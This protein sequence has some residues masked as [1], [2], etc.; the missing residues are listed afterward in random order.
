MDLEQAVESKHIYDAF[1]E[2]DKKNYAR[3]E[4]I[5]TEGLGLAE[6]EENYPL[7]AIFYS[8]LG[9]LAKLKHDFRQAWRYY[10][11]AEKLLPHNPVL[12]LISA[13]LLID[14]FSQYDVA[15]RKM[16]KIEDMRLNDPLVEH[17][18]DAIYGLA[19]T[20]S[21]NKAKARAY[22]QKLVASDFSGVV[23]ADNIDFKLVEACVR[24]G[25]HVELCHDYITKAIAFAKSTHNDTYRHLFERLLEA[26]EKE[27]INH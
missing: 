16:K 15:I 6:K 20:Q 27:Q 23:T 22:L 14:T 5:L 25:W 1:A 9:V 19:Y 13:R 3:A 10:D 11:Q 18:V 26:L 2:I 12:K 8:T 17:Q 4:E 7:V 24:K 21:G